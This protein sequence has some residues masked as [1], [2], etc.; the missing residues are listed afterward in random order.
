[1]VKLL[2]LCNLLV[3]VYVNSKKN[4]FFKMF[5]CFLGIGCFVRENRKIMDCCL[6]LIVFSCIFSV[7]I[8]K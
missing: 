6:F 1:M 2:I 3:K 4:F 5:L 8:I 7:L